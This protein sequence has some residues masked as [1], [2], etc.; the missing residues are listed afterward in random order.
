[1]KRYLMT[2]LVAIL[3]LYCAGAV[4][5]SSSSGNG[6]D[7]AS[8]HAWGPYSKRYAGISHIPDMRKGIRFDFSVMPGYYRNR[9]LVPHVLFESSYYPWEINPEMTR[10]TYRYELEWKD[11][12]YTDVTYHILD[13]N[14][15]LVGIR[16]VNRTGTPQNLVLN[17]MA[18]IDYPETQPQ[19]VATGTSRLQWY[20]AIDYVENAPV[21]K[22]PQYCLVYDGWQR[23]EE[24]SASSLDGSILGRGFGR[25]EGDRLVYRVNIL[26]GYENGAIGLRFKVKEGETAVLHLKGL[27]ERSVELRGTG[28]FSFLSIPY[29]CEKAGE[30]KLE[31]ISAST[32]GISL[33]GFFVGDSDEISHVNITPTPIPFTPVMEV[34][35]GRKDFIL[36]YKDC[37]NFYGVAWNYQHS[38]VREILN[39]EL[40][41]FFR[42]RVHDH[43]SSRL[44]G[45][46]KWHYA[47]AFLRPVVLEPNSEQTIYMLVCSGDKELVKRELSGFH[48]APD[49]FITQ[50]QPAKGMHSKDRILPAGEKYLLGTRLLQASLL[51]NIVYPVYTQKE[52][53]R[54]FT[55]GKNWNSLY[56]WDSGF[57][58][59]GLV[60]VDPAKAFECI[61]AYTTPVG[62]ESAFI[63]HGT[64]LP[65]Q[66]YACFDLWNNS[67]SRESL[68]FLYPRLKQ[69]FD[70]MVGNDPYSTTRMQGSG[71]LRTWDYFYN[72]GGWDDYPPQHALRGSKSQYQSVT[73]VV[74]SAYYLRAAKILRLA[75]KEL[76]L[77]RDVKEYEQVIGR[78][79]YALQ[80]YAWD[81]ESGYYGYVVH[82]SVGNAKEIF[83]YKDQS[84]FNKGLDGVTPL[85]AG[86]CSS[87]Q[88]GKLMGHLFSPDELW[89][90]VGISTVDQSA[91][92]YLEDGYWNGAVWF[93]H[94]WMMW[95][96]LL[97]LGKGEEA[98]RVAHTALN[99]WEKECEE[100][101][102]T[103]EHFI[104]SSGRGAGWHQFSGLSSPILNWFAAY[105]RPGKVSTGF[106]VWIT[107]S[108]FTDNYA[109]YKAEISFDD[110]TK[111]HERCMIVCMDVAGRKYE[112]RF[113][114]K[115]VRFKSVHAGML[116]ITL[117]A[118]NKAGELVVQAF[119]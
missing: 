104:I 70:F 105:Y 4:F 9:Q 6:H 25:N 28:E 3:A 90:N 58:A 117:P 53:I 13:D 54:H 113:N 57:I 40:E 68:A 96:A 84:N 76:G 43:V 10:I 14:R 59:L 27:T 22:S 101:Y 83:R 71:L 97:D 33:D 108:E 106:E 89:T 23:N 17:Q 91:P 46:R 86:I 36:K 102:F 81:E 100:S 55:P 29:R 80:T 115:P 21:C 64:P 26:P 109:G 67:L 31:F 18:Y 38:E 50:V 87:D 19:V 32:V 103:F 99:N 16:C 39:G 12:V 15:T 110:S 60:D 74:T 93:P 35:E 69:Y 2:F 78:L 44:V 95:K 5:P 56:T 48:L 45:D 112:V 98:Y 63:H 7:I 79:S 82:D 66:M 30:Y 49:K 73:P 116:E 94:Q 41:S 37:E 107:K 92:Y 111:P 119:D 72:S 52:Y 51:S 62:N 1:M 42:R 65:I 11:R 75:A 118:T 8:L 20:N 61:K 24:R 47:N 88:V 34:G 114:D 77:K 85:V